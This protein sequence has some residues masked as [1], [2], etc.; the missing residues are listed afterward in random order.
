MQDTLGT[1]F[2]HGPLNR[3]HAY[4]AVAVGTC[5][6]VVRIA[7]T[8]SA[9]QINEGYCMHEQCL[10]VFV[11]VETAI[12]EIKMSASTD[13][14]PGNNTNPANCQLIFS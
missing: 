4:I 5:I 8:N 6:H 7:G 12:A 1:M 11:S 9:L 10:S 14:R 13:N 3:H 2:D